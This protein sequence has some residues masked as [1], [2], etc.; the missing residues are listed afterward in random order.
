MRIVVCDIVRREEY[1]IEE[2]RLVSAIMASIVIPGI[3]EPV[4]CKGHVLIDGGVVNP[5]PVD[6]L[7]REGIKRI[8]AI[9]ILPSPVNITPM[10]I[11]DVTVYDVIV[12]SFQ[13]MGYTI[14]FFSSQQVEVYIH[15]VSVNR[16]WYELYS[17]KPFIRV[18]EKETRRVFLK[19]RELAK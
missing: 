3:F 15:P 9:N 8:I 12:S 4:R 2:G 11:S 13:C 16:K 14:V 19:M 10:R 7:F 17:S 6:V 18:G 5:L 1:V